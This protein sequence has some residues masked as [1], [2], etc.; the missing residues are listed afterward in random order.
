MLYECSIDSFLLLYNFV[1]C[2][3]LSLFLGGVDRVLVDDLT[4]VPHVALHGVSDFRVRLH[5]RH[6]GKLELV[7]LDASFAMELVSD[8][9]LLNQHINGGF[10]LILLLGFSRLAL[11]LH[12]DDFLHGRVLL[13]LEVL[14]GLLFADLNVDNSGAVK[15]L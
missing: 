8:S 2:L 6:Q 5:E 4:H 10:H 11:G 7:V 1:L 15:L 3:A 9:G 13:L 14:H 12:V